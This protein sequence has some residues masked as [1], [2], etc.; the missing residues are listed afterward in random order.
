MDPSFLLAFTGY[1][2][3]TLGPIPELKFAFCLFRP[4]VTLLDDPLS[5]V[6][7]RVGRTLFNEAIMGVMSGEGGGIIQGWGW[8]I[9]FN[10]AITRVMSGKGRGITL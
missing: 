3:S 6:D 9:L 7:P 8:R 1:T 2:I 10:E 5:A 4:D